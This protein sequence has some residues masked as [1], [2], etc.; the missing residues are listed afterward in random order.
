MKYDPPWGYGLV[1]KRMKFEVA[2]W[3]EALCLFLSSGSSDRDMF[4]FISPRGLLHPVLASEMVDRVQERFAVVDA[5]P[6]HLRD[7]F[8]NISDLLNFCSLDSS[9]VPVF[10]SQ[11]SAEAMRDIGERD[12][13]HS[14]VGRPQI[15]DA[16]HANV[17]IPL[18]EDDACCLCHGTR[19]PFLISRHLCPLCFSEELT[20]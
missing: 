6:A 10:E 7:V 15:E 8:N 5:S 11:T 18:V 9:E 20:D 14:N 1:S 4:A 12:V 16:M 13:V 2:D 17:G 19:H 3:Y